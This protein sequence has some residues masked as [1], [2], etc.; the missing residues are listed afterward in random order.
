MRKASEKLIV[1]S[2]NLLFCFPLFL[3]FL[4]SIVFLVA[5]MYWEQALVAQGLSFFCQLISSVA[6]V[7]PKENTWGMIYG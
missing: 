6:E 3:L 5:I 2:F 1:M 4:F 7:D